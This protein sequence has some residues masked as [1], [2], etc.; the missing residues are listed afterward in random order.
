[1]IYI[2]QVLCSSSIG[3]C[4]AR[5]K[6]SS[7]PLADSEE[8]GALDVSTGSLQESTGSLQESYAR[9]GECIGK[10]LCVRR[11]INETR[12]QSALAQ[13][14]VHFLTCKAAQAQALLKM[15]GV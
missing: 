6:I 12:L 10:V 13:Q 9:A 3:S 5:F 15:A 1:M 8:V 7:T 2:M 4:R 14:R 11:R